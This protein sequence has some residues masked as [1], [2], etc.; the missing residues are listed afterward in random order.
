ML[1]ST[2]HQS[3]ADI[4]E[5]VFIVFSNFEDENF[6]FHS[7]GT[8][9]HNDRKNLLRL[10]LAYR[11]F[12]RPALHF[13]WKTLPSD[14]PLAELLCRLG[15]ARK[16]PPSKG[17]SVHYVSRAAG[18]GHI[19]ELYAYH[20]L[21]ATFTLSLLR[22]GCALQGILET[23]QTGN[24]SGSTHPVCARLSSTHLSATTKDP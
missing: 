12:V 14:I 4:Q 20:G 9:I 8:F 19:T 10:A 21:T 17:Q 22:S 13:L 2:N 23:T 1:K 7:G 16:E 3:I 6:A 11:N 15:I 18:N 5:I 24:V